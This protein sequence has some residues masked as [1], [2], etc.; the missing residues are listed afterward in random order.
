[1]KQLSPSAG[2]PAQTVDWRFLLPVQSAGNIL[3]VEQNGSDLF[4]SFHKLGI[5]VKAVT[6]SGL[7]GL[8]AEKTFDIVAAPFGLG[9]STRQVHRSEYLGWIQSLSN[10]L[11]TGGSLLVGIQNYWNAPYTLSR[12]LGG[13]GFDSI[14]FYAAIPDLFSPNYVLPVGARV[15][16]FVLQHRYQHRLTGH[17][18]RYLPSLVTGFLE[19]FLPCYYLVAVLK[20]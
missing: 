4:L 10:L 19:N 3:V 9:D 17:I 7:N 5:P 12:R 13:L 2:V 1:M 20:Q 6:W 16:K 18:A 14:R 15:I 8:S 11:R